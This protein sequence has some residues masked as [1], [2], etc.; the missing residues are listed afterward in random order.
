MWQRVGARLASRPNTLAGAAVILFVAVLV[1]T[2][3]WLTT[4]RRERRPDPGLVRAST[5]GTQAPVRIGTRTECPPGWPVLAASNPTSYPP[6]HPG[7]PPP[8]GPRSPAIRRPLRRPALAMPRHRRQPACWRSAA[9]TSPR[10]AP[11]SEPAAGG[12]PTG[13]SSPCPAPDCCPPWRRACSRRDCVRSHPPAR[14]DGSSGSSGTGS[15]SRPATA[16]PPT[17]APW[18]SPP[19]RPPAAPT[20]SC[21]RVRMRAGWLRRPCTRPGRCWRPAPRKANSRAGRHD[22][23]ALV[24]AGPPGGGRRHGWSEVNQRLVVAVAEHLRLVE[25]PT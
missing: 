6:G 13:S 22:A 25:P 24:P 19:T 17:T 12:P 10:P 7:K 14:A 5:A 2:G 23:V 20:G 4:D 9:S 21:R 3:R 1:L 16:A 11:A 8:G 18:T 15:R